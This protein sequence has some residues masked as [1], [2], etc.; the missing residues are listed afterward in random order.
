MTKFLHIAEGWPALMTSE[1]AG[2]YLSVSEEMLHR[3]AARHTVHAVLVESEDP[4]WRKQDLDRLVRK[5]P[6]SADT[7]M[8]VRKMQIL[9]LDD[10]DV[11]S[12][13]NAV[14][15]R[16]GSGAALS[17]RR[18]VSIREAGKM[19]GIGRSTVYRMMEDGRLATRKIGRR[20]LVQVDSINVLTG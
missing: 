14:A 9:R 3:L 6:V 15:A 1:M 17:E 11:S 2:R 20:T 13:A 8:P 7:S 18:L 12:I 4:R 19:L 16:L 10:H 5:L